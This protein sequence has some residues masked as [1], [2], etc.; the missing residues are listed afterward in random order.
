MFSKQLFDKVDYVK[1][2][3][4]FTHSQLCGLRMYGDVMLSWVSQNILKENGKKHVRP[5]V[6][7]TISTL[8]L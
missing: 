3:L 5:S 2:L 6:Y 1:I 4:S 7:S 8:N